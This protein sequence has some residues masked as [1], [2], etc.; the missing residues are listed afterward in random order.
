MKS[1][2]TNVTNPG[3]NRRIDLSRYSIFI[4]VFVVLLF[5]SLS[6]LNFFT[7]QNI[8]SIFYGLSIE[9]YAVLGLTLLLI[10]GEVD[11]SVSSVFA[12]AGIFTGV[13][14]LKAELP[15]WIAIP[16][17]LVLCGII[18][19]INGFFIVKFKINSLM[20]TIGTMILFRGIADGLIRLLE[21]VTYPSQYR[22]I[23]KIKIAGEFNITIIFLIAIIII[24]EILL[25][26]NI[27]FRK[28]YYIG[29]NIMSARL[30]GI[31][32]DKIKIIIFILSAI[33]AGIAG[34]LTASRSGHS[35][36]NT[37]VGLEFKMITAAILGGA[38][39]YGGK[40]SI[41]RSAAGLLFLATLFNGFVMYNVD[42]VFTGVVTGAVLIAVI[43]IDT[44]ISREKIEY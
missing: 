2:T 42:P 30:Y 17:S 15:I 25:I 27:S 35:V 6:R 10:M 40:G 9:F 21:G 36:S 33:G 34:I 12:F 20:M 23:S 28:L 37:G 39:L 24:L 43:I 31:N 32:T 29:Q 19:F 41:L 14:V 26:Y 3:K 5:L 1:E 13:M 18:G 16:I 7:Y 8:Y 22:M 38:S 4:I 11:L 44:R